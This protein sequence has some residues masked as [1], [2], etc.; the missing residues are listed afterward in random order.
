MGARMDKCKAED[1]ADPKIR[2]FAEYTVDYI[3]TN[4][5]GSWFHLVSV[6]DA[7]R[8]NGFFGRA[9]NR[10]DQG[11]TDGTCKIINARTWEHEYEYKG[12]KD[13]VRG[14]GQLKHICDCQCDGKADK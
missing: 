7:E 13:Y 5:N 8:L 14:T 10:K 11:L 9:W 1:P 12:S 6:M 3:N 4:T 2:S